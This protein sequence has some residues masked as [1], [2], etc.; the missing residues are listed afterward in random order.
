MTNLEVAKAAATVNHIALLSPSLSLDTLKTTPD[1]VFSLWWPQDVEAET[2]AKFADT[3][4]AERVGIVTAVDDI[5]QNFKNRL[6]IH[7]KEA[8]ITNI[9]SA[10]IS[11]NF[12]QLEAGVVKNNPQVLFVV[13]SNA[14][15]LGPLLTDLKKAAPAASLVGNF[16]LENP[17]LIRDYGK[18]LDSLV[19]SYPSFVTNDYLKALSAYKKQH[20]A[21]ADDLHYLAAYNT[22]VAAAT[23]L[24]QGALTQPAA[25]EKIG[26]LNTKGMG[27]INLSFGKNHQLESAAFEFR[28]IKNGEYVLYK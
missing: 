12:K 23:L 4:H 6:V 3:N 8:G 2:L 18:Q 21:P 22:G 27:N 19:Y 7:L 16:A 17:T 25:L 20:G 28:T 15:G 26:H 1:N 13:V 9:T 10:N 14:Q 24:N 5:S 11:P